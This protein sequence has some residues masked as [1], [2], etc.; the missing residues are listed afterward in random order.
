MPCNSVAF[1]AVASLGKS[2]IVGHSIRIGALVGQR[3]L[4]RSV[5]QC[6]T[7]RRRSAERMAVEDED[8]PTDGQ[9]VDH[10]R[11][12]FSRIDRMT[13]QNLDLPQ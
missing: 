13:P 5:C 3:T 8:H 6:G 4:P 12:Y 11:W 10:A 9:I 7:S 1:V 2:D